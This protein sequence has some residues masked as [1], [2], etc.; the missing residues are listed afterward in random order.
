MKM[1]LTKSQRG[2]SL[3]EL[4]I[5]ATLGVLLIL[6]MTSLFRTGMNTTF[7]V[8][9]RAETQ[10]N[11]R[12]AIELLTKD[13]SL[14]GSGLPT[15][16][17]QLATAG[18]ATKVACNY[19]N[20][21]CYVPA[22]VYNGNYMTGILPGFGN[23]VQNSAVIAAAP[24]ATNDSITSIYCDYNFPLN[25]FTFAF[26]TSTSATAT[27]INAAVTPNNILAPGGLNVG[28]LMLFTVS[29]AGNGTTSQ[30]TSSVQTAAAVGEIT[31]LAAP[32]NIAF[33]FGDALNFNQAVGDANSLAY[34]IQNSMGGGTTVTAC[35]LEAVSYFLEV[36]AV[37]GTVQTPRLMRQVNALPAVAVAD[38]IIN[39]QFSY[40]VISSTTGLMNANLANVIAAGDSPALIQKVNMWV[41]G[42]SLIASG[43]KSQ[44][45]Y[46]ASSVSTRNMSFCNSYSNSTTVCQ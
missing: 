43:D 36:P 28:D 1:R 40:D 38:N 23:G 30:G 37:G 18:G 15:G 3:L 29:S 9:Q 34:T 12:A 13:I 17:L 31:G 19:Q 4:M 33:A 32:G 20:G 35:R 7:T 26:P 46:L 11:M 27:V 6:A 41:M 45:M 16:G 21:T 25:N 10:Q 14:A 22:D 39:L 42:Q 8:T 2:F 24:A 5:A 44:S